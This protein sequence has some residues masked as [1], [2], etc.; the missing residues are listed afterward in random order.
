MVP[1]SHTK[2]SAAGV[3]SSARI[4]LTLRSEPYLL[5]RAVDEH[6]VELDLLV[7]SGATRPGEALLPQSTGFKTQDRYDQRWS[8]PAAKADILRARTEY[9]LEVE[10]PS[11]Q[12]L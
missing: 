6:R 8:Y 11:W 9:R 2:R 3:T 7:Q 5:W 1:W 10:R 4:R 12:L